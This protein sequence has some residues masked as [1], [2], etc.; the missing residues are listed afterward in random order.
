MATKKTNTKAAVQPNG[1]SQPTTPT[2]NQPQ[3]K[4]PQGA[5]TKPALRDQFGFGLDT[6]NH[7]FGEMLLRDGGCTM[8]EVREAEWNTKGITFYNAYNALAKKGLADKQLRT[9]GGGLDVECSQA[10]AVCSRATARICALSS[11]GSRAHIRM[12]WASSASMYA[13]GTHGSCSDVP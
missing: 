8:R 3:P 7:K 1:Q 5:D 2:S 10:A 11:A 9:R 13:H 6:R 4:P 12:T